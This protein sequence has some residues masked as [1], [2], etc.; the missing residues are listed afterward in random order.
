MGKYPE[1]TMKAMG[2]FEIF[3][4]QT[5]KDEKKSIEKFQKKLS[6]YKKNNKKGYKKLVCS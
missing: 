5:L 1:N 4:M 3:Y 6:K 2:Y